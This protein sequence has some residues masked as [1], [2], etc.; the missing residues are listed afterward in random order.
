MPSL[1][2]GFIKTGD[3]WY[4]PAGMLICEKALTD[5]SVA[6]RQGLVQKVTLCSLLDSIYVKTF[7]GF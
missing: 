5:V 4:T 7:A 3:V 2:A 6:L 1:V